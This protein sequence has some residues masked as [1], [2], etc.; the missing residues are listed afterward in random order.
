MVQTRRR[1]RTLI[2]RSGRGV[3]VDA[4]LRRH[5]SAAGLL[6]V[7]LLS[8]AIVTP[9]VPRMINPYDE[10][11]V[12]YGAERVLH[13]QRPAVDFYSPYGP[14]VFYT[15][16]AAYR[17]FGTRLLVERW[18]TALLL[19]AVGGLSYLLLER[20]RGPRVPPGADNDGGAGVGRSP[21]GGRAGANAAGA[22]SGYSHAGAGRWQTLR[23]LRH[24]V[25]A[26]VA[27]LTVVLLLASGWW[28][29]PVNGGVLALVL[30]SG[31]AL[32]QA[33]ATGSPGWAAAAG[34]AAGI[35][36]TWRL[37]FGGALLIAN[38]V[39]WAVT[40]AGETAEERRL[41]RNVGLVAL[42][43]AAVAIALPVYAGLIAA[44]GRRSWMSLIV[45]PLTSTEAANLPWP[46]LRLAPP[47]GDPSLLTRLTA[48]THGASFYY[49]GVTLLLMLWR[50]PLGPLSPVDRRLG[51]WLASMLPPL[52]LYAHGR[53]DYLH[54]TPLLVFSLLLAAVLVVPSETANREAPTTAPTES[55]AR[56]ARRAASLLHP[57]DLLQSAWKGFGLA[58][59]IVSLLLLVPGVLFSAQQIWASPGRTPLELPGPRG[60]GVYA[61]YRYSRQY[62]ALAPL[63]QYH[64]A[65]G[66]SIYSGTTRHDIYLTNDILLYFLAERN[67]ATYYWCLDA[68]LTSSEAVQQEM[69]AEMSHG[70]VAMAVNWTDPK[71]GENNASGRSSCVRLL[72]EWLSREFVSVRLPGI[73]YDV[74]VRQELWRRPLASAEAN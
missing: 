71:A 6:L 18:V 57:R 48:A 72:D 40:V 34:A 37:T 45:W 44:G 74:R 1:G 4:A 9:L 3:Q 27:A 62:R 67:A 25:I 32:Q 7:L 53:T 38:A 16:A 58:V 63:I 69:L 60:A 19:I 5:A 33:L 23:E 51:L 14:G 43:A 54:V 61:P 13:G 47:E 29:T 8:L 31:L 17:L 39:T 22:S 35:A 28:Y 56:A 10:G 20:R 41:N 11:M 65:P 70:A 73:M 59:W 2:V 36:M 68:G 66:Q 12:A 64:V 52:F 24:L 49:T 30:L 26:G 15:V 42:V 46:P 55:S 21:H 50:L